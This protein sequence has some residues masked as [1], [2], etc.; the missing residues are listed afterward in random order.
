MDLR[1]KIN[2]APGQVLKSQNPGFLDFAFYV[3]SFYRFLLK[4]KFI[5]TLLTERSLVSALVCSFVSIYD[6]TFIGQDFTPAT[7]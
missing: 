4:I 1:V 2:T 3:H 5:F 6:F 7:R